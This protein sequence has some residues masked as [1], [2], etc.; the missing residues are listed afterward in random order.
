MGAD[1]GRESEPLISPQRWFQELRSAGFN[2]KDYFCVPSDDEVHRHNLFLIARL[3]E[4]ISWDRRVSLLYCHEKPEFALKLAQRLQ[5]SNFTVRWLKFGDDDSAG[6][7]VIS[8]IDLGKPL[9]Q[10]ISETDLKAL[11]TFLANTQSS[12][13]WLM[14]PAQVCCSDPYQSMILGLTRI[15]RLELGLQ[16]ATLEL[17]KL[18]AKAEEATLAIFEKVRSS[19]PSAM[20]DAEREFVVHEDVVHV[21]RYYPFDLVAELE[22]SPPR[23][24]TKCLTFGKPGLLDE[25]GWRH[26]DQD[27]DLL[28]DDHVEIDVRCTGLNFRVSLVYLGLLASPLLLTE[29]QDLVTVMG[30]VTSPDGLLGYEASGIVTRVGS[31]VSH[32]KVGDRVVCI[33]SGCFAARVRK[34][35]ALVSTI[36]DGWSFEEAATMPVSFVTAIYSLVNLG[37]VTKGQ[38]SVF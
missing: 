29:R 2:G 15:A 11:L 8:C 25:M 12:V 18:G 5:V 9:L 4:P 32:V 14:R 17:P 28:T 16:I 21:G 1:D 22:R 31:L 24:S 26:S 19:Q 37:Q 34:P 33:G 3:P 20:L 38:V 35:G 13:L 6:E 30:L 27:L 7:D 36:P 10:A 23:G